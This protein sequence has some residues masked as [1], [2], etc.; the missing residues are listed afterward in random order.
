MAKWKLYYLLPLLLLAMGVQVY[1]QNA[2]LD[3]LK[4]QIKEATTD[5]I[6]LYWQI[7]YC[8]RNYKIN[9][10]AA[11]IELQKIKL[12][13]QEK[14]L[15]GLSARASM[16]MAAVFFD[17][18]DYIKSIINDEEAL[19]TYTEMVPGKNRSWGMSACYINLGGT[20]SNINDWEAAQRYYYQGIAEL[21]HQKDSAAANTAYF[22]LA[23][24][25]IDMQE[26]EKA[27]QYLKKA[28]EFR[29]LSDFRDGFIQT[30]A[31][32]AAICCKINKTAEAESL[33][34]LCD[35]MLPFSTHLLGKIY[36]HNAYGDYFF[37]IGNYTRALNAHLQAYRYANSFKDPYYIADE[38][39]A[40]GRIYLQLNQPDSAQL[41]L[42]EA[43]DLAHQHNYLAKVRVILNDW[44]EYYARNKKF[45]KAYEYRTYLN[46]FADSLVK[47]QNH[48]RIF[49][50]D[51][52]YQTQRK[53]QHIKELENEKKIQEL[54]L[55][56]K[57]IFNYVLLGSLIALLL[58]GTLAYRNFQNKQQLSNQTELLHARRIRELEQ[59]KLLISMNSLL[60]GQE[61]ERGRL[62][63]DLH[64][65]LGGMLS[66]VKLSL[67][68]MKGNLILSEDNA[69]LFSRA[70][71]QLDNSIGEMRRV[72]HNMMPEALVRLGLQQA[73][74]DYCDGLSESQ[75]LKINCLFFGLESRLDAATEIVVYRIVQELL[76]NIVKHAV[77]TEALVQ[78]MRHDNNLNITVEDD[79]K[80]FLLGESSYTKGAGLSNIRTRVDYLK[81]QLDIQSIPG[82]GTSIHIDCI[83][84]S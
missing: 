45:E 54:S 40:I 47:V 37:A 5:S 28:V 1:S 58:I 59:E 68:A 64:D 74:Q 61:E 82:K 23:F 65:G 38:S 63:K 83:I 71:N 19:K 26:W 80:G 78:V 34:K 49:L 36:Y 22:N 25:F 16:S 10:S 21:E 11:L 35:S 67:G 33:L 27:Y 72:A 56:Q 57:S 76:N 73:I 39:R 51:T 55:K 43:F 50:N 70:L 13:S 7:E 15:Y 60:K 41:Y 14:K 77:A 24:L 4:K 12:I 2:I 9:E 79:G 81:G 66:G 8:K 52:K 29:N 84:E 44:S 48:N 20:Y 30:P 6:R 18:G 46:H 17:K 75:P 3:S 62:A 31:R 69:R 42:A 53:E 32:L